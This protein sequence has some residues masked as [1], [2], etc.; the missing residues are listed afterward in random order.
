MYVDAFYTCVN[1]ILILGWL[2]SD[3]V[4]LT[5]LYSIFNKK[6]QLEQKSFQLSEKLY[7]CE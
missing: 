4:G 2:I 7:E 1:W 5:I 6:F 3:F